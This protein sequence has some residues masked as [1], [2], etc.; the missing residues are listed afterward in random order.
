MGMRKHDASQR[1]MF[2]DG[3]E[4]WV[5]EWLVPGRTQSMRLISAW[6]ISP[7]DSVPF[8]VSCYLKKVKR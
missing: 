5:V 1:Y 3:T 8:L 7:V 4:R 6:N 2:P